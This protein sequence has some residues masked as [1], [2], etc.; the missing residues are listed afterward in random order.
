MLRRVMSACAAQ[1]SRCSRPILESAMQDVASTSSPSCE[2]PA[3][4]AINLIF[5]RTKYTYRFKQSKDVPGGHGSMVHG[6]CM[7]AWCTCRS[8]YRYP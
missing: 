7:T 4:A 1:I 3:G 8:H 5:A 6:A 2:Y